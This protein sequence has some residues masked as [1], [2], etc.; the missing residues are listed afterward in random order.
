MRGARRPQAVTRRGGRA[1]AGREENDPGEFAPLG[2][3]AY[4]D[5]RIA[6]RELVGEESRVW[7]LESVWVDHARHGS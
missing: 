1:N 6:K 7:L 4:C 2:Y 5:A 3:R